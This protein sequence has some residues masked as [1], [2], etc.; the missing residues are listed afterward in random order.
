MTTGFWRTG[1]LV[2]ALTCVVG[3]AVPT[4]ARA[5]S[6]GNVNFVIGAK[7]LDEDDW[8][9]NEGQPEFGAEVTWGGKT[10]P[11]AIAT[12]LVASSHGGDVLGVEIN[13]RTAEWA[14]G[15]RKIWEAGA[16][17]PYIGGGIARME[18]EKEINHNTEQGSGL[19]TW[20][21][22]GIFWRLGS[23]FNIGLAARLSRGQ[24]TLSGGDIEAGGVHAGLLLGWG[25][26][27][28]K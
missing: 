16:A 5:E 10:W 21:G 2:T 26:P 25:W 1:V 3:L 4:G 28:G 17:R 27:A 23:R 13:A 14:F 8:K 24:V 20:I 22:G 11:I 9:P 19:G 6:K 12:D 7:G 15:V 18:A